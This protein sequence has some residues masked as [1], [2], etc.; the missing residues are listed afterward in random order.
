MK[1]SMNGF[2]LIE[3]LVVIGIIALMASIVLVALNESRI[4]SR[5][6]NRMSQTKEILNAL[7]LYYTQFGSYPTSQGSA[8]DVVNLNQTGAADVIG[9]A[10][11]SGYMSA[12]PEDP[13]YE[14]TSSNSY[15][16]CSRSSTSF[17]LY[18]NLENDGDE[19]PVTGRCHIT[20]GDNLGLCSDDLGGPACDFLVR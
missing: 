10:L 9:T 14:Y 7:E 11:T 2:S 18:I 5:D 15:G 6:G 13:L 19:D 8:D 3:L 17:V 16:Y 4:R 20:R 1:R 12:I